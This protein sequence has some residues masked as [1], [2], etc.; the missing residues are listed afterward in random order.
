MCLAVCHEIVYSAAPTAA[1]APRT[2]N[3]NKHRW[4][5]RLHYRYVILKAVELK[6]IQIWV[7]SNCNLYHSSWTFYSPDFSRVFLQLGPH[8]INKIQQDATVCS[9][10]FTTKLFYMFRVSITPIIRST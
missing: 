8:Y 2:T 6:R 1:F 3:V 5:N 4:T 10:L 7:C 9:Y